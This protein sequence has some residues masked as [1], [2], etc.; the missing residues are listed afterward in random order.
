MMMYALLARA[1]SNI[2][3]L[4]KLYQIVYRCMLMIKKGGK[5]VFKS[6][7]FMI[8]TVTTSNGDNQLLNTIE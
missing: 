1:N 7:I 3:F 5:V 6:I 8:N 4:H 2:C